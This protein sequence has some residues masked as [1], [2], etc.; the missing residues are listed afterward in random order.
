MKARHVLSRTSSAGPSGHLESRTNAPCER[1][2]HSTHSVPLPPLYED[3]THRGSELAAIKTHSLLT[4]SM[5]S[6]EDS[7]SSAWALR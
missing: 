3:L 1:Y 7:R 4:R 2:A 6:T 5:S